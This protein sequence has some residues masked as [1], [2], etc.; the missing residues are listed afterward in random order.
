ML[1][2]GKQ[3]ASAVATVKARGWNF[4]QT[5]AAPQRYFFDIGPGETRPDFS[6]LLTWNRTVTA[7]PDWQHTTSTLANLS[8]KLYA[9]SGFTIGALVDASDSAIDNVEHVYAPNLPPGR[10]ALEVTS[11]Q[12]G[13]NYGLAWYSQASVSVAATIPTASEYGAVAGGFTVTRTGD[14]AD[15]LTLNCAWAG[16][17]TNGVD[18]A[19]LPDAVTIPAGASSVQIPVLPVADDLAEG[20]ETVTLTIANDFAYSAGAA[21][22]AVVTIRDRPIDAWRFARFTAAELA[23]PAIGGDLG[24]ADGDGLVN[25]VEYALGLNP[26]LADATAVPVVTIN[27]SGFLSLK[28]TRPDSVID[29]TYVV[30]VASAVP[31]WQSGPEFTT[32]M[33]LASAPGTQTFEVASVTPASG[34][35]RQFIRLRIERH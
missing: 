26:K 19:V 31:A 8:L 10:Y 32:T 17:A 9:A 13:L 20:D 3:P 30:E 23:D 5:S 1:V 16:T 12:T 22:S 21:A 2:A 14:T 24:D 6:A 35:P 18:C 25:R 7:L 34:Q 4:A 33:A 11:T 15:P 29:M 27:A 28:Y